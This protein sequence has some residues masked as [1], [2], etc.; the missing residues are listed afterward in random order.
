[1]EN[2]KIGQNIKPVFYAKKYIVPAVLIIFT[3]VFCQKTFSD[4]ISVTPN[5]LF[6]DVQGSGTATVKILND[7]KSPLSNIPV[8]ARSNKESVVTVAPGIGL[9]NSNGQISFTIAGISNGT[10]TITFNTNTLSKSL[11]VSVVSNIAPCAIADSSGGGVDEFG[12]EMMNDGVEKKDCSYH[13]I[14]TRKEVGQ[15]K[16]GWIRLDWDEDVTV[17]RMIIQTTDCN[18]SCG[19][20]PDDTLYIDSGRNVG[21]GIVQYLDED[22]ITW[23]TDGEFIEEIG[24]VEYSFTKPITTKAIRIKKIAPSTQCNGQQ[25]NPVVFEWKVY[26]TPS[27][28]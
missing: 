12:P 14:R 6:I 16:S 24:D 11:P 21:N 20:D 1:M 4:S 25:S 2:R 17:T 23:I 15:K 28:N 8:A 18:E 7:Q 22:E 19:N 26:G 9:T 27:C 13:W 3:L 5:L 10:A